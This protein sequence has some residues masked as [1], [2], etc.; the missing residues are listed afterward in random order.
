MRHNKGM[1]FSKD[2]VMT[3]A[4]AITLAGLLIVLYGCLHINTVAGLVTIAVGRS[5][6]LIDG[7][8]AR[9]TKRTEFSVYMDPT[10]DKLAMLGILLGTFYYGLA[11]WWVIIYVFLQNLATSVV[12]IVAQHKKTAVGALWPGKINLF[13]QTCAIFLFIAGHVFHSLPA[14]AVYAAAYVCLAVSIPLAIWALK[15]Y[16]ALIPRPS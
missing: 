5:F 4:N 16:S 8:V 2:Q 12:S 15:A 3:P 1:T 10:A 11:P 7:P 9:A 6:D 14:H 13:L